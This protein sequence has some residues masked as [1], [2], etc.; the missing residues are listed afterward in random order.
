MKKLDCPHFTLT[1][2]LT[3]EQL[4]FFKVNGVIIFRKFVEPET[5]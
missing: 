3:S 1:E 4:D 2:T 5:V